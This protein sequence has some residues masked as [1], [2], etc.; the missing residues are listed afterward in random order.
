MAKRESQGLQIALILFVMIT[1]VLAITTYVYYRKSEEM[2]KKSI[3]ANDDARKA[4]ASFGKLQ[5]QTQLFK[6]MIGVASLSQ[7]D[8]AAARQGAGEEMQAIWTD[9]EN[10]MS[11]LGADAGQAPTYKDS[12]TF[13]IQAIRQRNTE[14]EDLQKEAQAHD[15]KLKQ[16]TAQET[17][18]TQQRTTEQARAQQD[19]VGER[20]Q[21]NEFREG[22]K[23]DNKKIGED[24]ASKN[25]ELSTTKQDLNAQI[26]DA[27]KESKSKDLTIQTQIKR[28]QEMKNETF[29][30]ADGRISYV[31]QATGVVWINLGMSDGMRR[32]I[33]FSVYDEDQTA[34]DDAKPKGSVEV[35]RIIDQHLSEARI[36]SVSPR[37]PILPGDQVFSP[38]WKPGRK[39]RFAMAGFFD[40]N[41][42]GRSDRDRVRNLITMNGGVIDAELHDDGNQTGELT[43]RTRYIVI[44]ERPTESATPEVLVGYNNLIEGAD[45]LGIERMSLDKLLGYLGFKGDVRTVALGAGARSEDFKPRKGVIQS[46]TAPT[47]STFRKRLPSRGG[48]GAYNK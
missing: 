45:D 9:Y 11:L 6:H 17:T 19:L 20:T 35:I 48:N 30:V 43:V 32:Q 16:V 34:V 44:G 5:L 8:I 15:D 13:F 22:M 18:R 36:T 42:D 47:S 7:T 10:H 14:V 41:E 31:N 1:I 21:F 37:D 33:S 23:G 27:K 26:V 2:V 40:I 25:V 4:K 3:T 38:S 12:P 24:L 39:I 28:L 46:S 29:E